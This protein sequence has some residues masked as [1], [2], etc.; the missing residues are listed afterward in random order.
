MPK[1][2]RRPYSL[3]GE[4]SLGTIPGNYQEKDS[5]WRDRTTVAPTNLDCFRLHLF[6]ILKLLFQIKS[7]KKQAPTRNSMVYH[8]QKT[9]PKCKLGLLRRS[10]R[11]LRHAFMNEWPTPFVTHNEQ[12][13]PGSFASEKLGCSESP[14]SY[15]TLYPGSPCSSFQSAD[16]GVGAS[17]GP[18]NPPAR[19][20][21]KSYP[22]RRREGLITPVRSPLIEC[23]YTGSS[24]EYSIQ[25]DPSLGNSVSPHTWNG[26]HSSTALHPVPQPP[27]AAHTSLE[28]SSRSIVVRAFTDTHMS[29]LESTDSHSQRERYS[30]LTSHPIPQLQISSH[31]LLRAPNRSPSTPD[32]HRS[33]QRENIQRHSSAR[34]SST[35]VIRSLP[36]CPLNARI[37]VEV[38]KCS[39]DMQAFYGFNPL[40]SVDRHDVWQRRSPLAS[41]TAEELSHKASSYLKVPNHSTNSPALSSDLSSASANSHDIG[42]I[43]SSPTTQPSYYRVCTSKTVPEYSPSTSPMYN[44]TPSFSTKSYSLGCDHSSVKRNRKPQSPYNAHTFVE[45]TSSALS[46]PTISSAI[47]PSIS[48]D[49]CQCESVCPPPSH[50]VPKPLL[51]TRALIEEP[52]GNLSAQKLYNLFQLFSEMAPYQLQP[53]VQ[54]IEEQNRVIMELRGQLP[55]MPWYSDCD[56][57]GWQAGCKQNYHRFEHWN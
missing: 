38:P 27:L 57:S 11:T 34:R 18:Y 36:R 4:T 17:I 30:P 13:N 31:P 9:S 41:H 5:T 21:D 53:Y 6:S 24:S 10:K 51:N 8:P 48:E 42:K 16:S 49:H 1:N 25:S 15:E 35:P 47:P 37:A 52:N 33:P 54:R 26:A 23:V 3:F 19:R 12:N 7:L 28:D 55:Q 20:T 45:S 32:L 29:G 44:I 56:A 50:A 2:E 22:V 43:H 46:I 40:E 14:P 39:R